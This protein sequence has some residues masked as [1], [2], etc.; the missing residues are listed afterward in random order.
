M[1]VYFYTR[2]HAPLNMVGDFPRKLC[3]SLGLIVG[4]YGPITG[5]TD[6]TRPRSGKETGASSRGKAREVL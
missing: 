3:G 6:L 4:F 2:K 1:R 5:A